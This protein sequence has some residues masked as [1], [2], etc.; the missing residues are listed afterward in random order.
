MCILT[1]SQLFSTPLKRTYETEN[2]DVNNKIN[3]NGKSTVRTYV[4]HLNVK[5]LISF[6]KADSHRYSHYKSD[7]E[8]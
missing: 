3:R 5:R 1:S 7:H 4:Y 8:Q 6:F 2:S